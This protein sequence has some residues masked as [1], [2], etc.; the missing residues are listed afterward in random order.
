VHLDLQL[1]VFFTVIV[2][3]GISCNFSPKAHSVHFISVHGMFPDPWP[4]GSSITGS[5]TPGCQAQLLLTLV[6]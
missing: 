3:A 1:L 4:R 2:L 6:A 5:A